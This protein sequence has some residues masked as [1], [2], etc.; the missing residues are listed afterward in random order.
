M[1][2]DTEI[3]GGGKGRLAMMVAMMAMMAMNCLL[4]PT[5]SFGFAVGKMYRKSDSIYKKVLC[6]G[7]I[8]IP[9]N[10]QG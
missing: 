2:Y 3:Q 1:L 6:S 5:A 7:D 4:L 8:P 10:C 9:K